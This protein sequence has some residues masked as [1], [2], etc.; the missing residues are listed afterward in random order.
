MTDWIKVSDRLPEKNGLYLA[1]SIFDKFEADKFLYKNGCFH[2]EWNND[3]RRCGEK[4]VTHWM[5]IPPKPT[6]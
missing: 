5:E 4:D 1:C 3:W 2:F 6:V